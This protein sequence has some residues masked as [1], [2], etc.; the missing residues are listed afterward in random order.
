VILF[1]LVCHI[2]QYLGSFNIHYI[3]CRKLK[4]SKIYISDSIFVNENKESF[5]IFKNIL[6]LTIIQINCND[7]DS[8]KLVYIEQL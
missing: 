2:L 1:H 6:F 5:E 7:N 4:F 8:W 3:I